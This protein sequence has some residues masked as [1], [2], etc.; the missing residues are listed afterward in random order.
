MVPPHRHE[1][2]ESLVSAG[3]LSRF[4]VRDPG[5]HGEVTMGTQGCGVFVDATSGF[6]RQVQSANDLM[7]SMGSKSWIVARACIAPLAC[8][9]GATWKT[10]VAVPNVHLSVAVPMTS[11]GMASASVRRENFLEPVVAGPPQQ[12]R[13]AFTQGE[14]ITSGGAVAA[15]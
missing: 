6:A 3:C 7:F 9:C 10:L 5:A 8:R 2:F 14:D 4:T 11:C 12:Q 15:S 13:T 1:H